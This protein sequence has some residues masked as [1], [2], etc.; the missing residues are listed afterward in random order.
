MKWATW[1]VV[2]LSGL[3]LVGRDAVA[4]TCYSSW[5]PPTEH[6]GRTTWVSIDEGDVGAATC[7]DALDGSNSAALYVMNDW[8]PNNPRNWWGR[9]RM[10]CYNESSLHYSSWY[11]D[12]NGNGATN[13]EAYTSC[14]NS[15]NTIDFAQAQ[16]FFSVTG[17]QCSYFQLYYG[18]DSCI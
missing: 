2:A 10:K 14:D 1:G 17:W 15:N 9:A 16:G 8:Y 7:V 5:S 13:P 6:N 3:L 12:T 4:D 11:E 18:Y